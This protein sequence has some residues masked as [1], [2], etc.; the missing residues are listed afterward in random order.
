MFVF[1]ADGDWGLNIRDWI[2][3]QASALAIAAIVIVVVP[4]IYKRQWSALIGT[5]FASGI[6]LFVV[7]QP[8]ELET[9]GK[10]LYDIIFK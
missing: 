6:A 2:I 10:V 7:N 3:R 4:L 9:I 5:I 1:A 8:D